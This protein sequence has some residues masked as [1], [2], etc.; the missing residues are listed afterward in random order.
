MTIFKDDITAAVSEGKCPK[1]FPANLVKVARR[2]IA[3]VLAAGKLDDLRSPPGNQLHTLEKDR[4]G[5]HAIRVNDQ[6]RICFIW[7]ANGAKEIEFT[8]YH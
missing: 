3:M 4:M 7:T 2:K 1:G 8:D 5:Q 6:F